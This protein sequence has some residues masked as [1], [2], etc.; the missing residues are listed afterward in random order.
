M[1]RSYAIIGTGAIGGFYGALLQQAGFDVHFLVRSD[2]AHVRA[3]GLIIE[4]AQRY[5]TLGRVQAYPRAEEMPRCDV[6]VVALKTTQNDVLPS[7]LPP[8]MKPQG[9]CL[10]LQ[11]GLGMEEE[12]ARVVGP[13]RVLGG[14]CFICSNKTGPGV[15]HHLDYG[16]IM[17]GDFSADGAP[18]GLTPR[19]QQL[20]CDFAATGIPVRPVEDLLLA[21]WKKLV[22]NI[23]FNA[24]SV[25]LD[26]ATDRIMAEPASAARVR[27]IMGDVVALAAAAGRH[28]DP[29]FVQKMLDDTARMKPYRTSMKIDFDS[30]RPLEVEAIYGNPLRFARARRVQ[31][32]EIEQLYAQ[33]KAMEVGGP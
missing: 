8:V 17:L 28:I 3:R 11:N 23:P 15:I 1:T 10:V 30:R 18:R 16:D 31:V 14:L 6:V 19:L 7:L 20:A 32:P 33:L 2:Y 5:L 26:A 29:A 24:L 4:S 13:D 12:A 9:L 22:W 27:R 21:R 25:I